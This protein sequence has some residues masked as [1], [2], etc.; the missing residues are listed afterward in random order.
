MLRAEV[1]RAEQFTRFNFD[2]PLIA[3]FVNWW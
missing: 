2:A 1:P 3:A